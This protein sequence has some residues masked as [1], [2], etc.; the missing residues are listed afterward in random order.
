MQ[1]STGNAIK[2]NTQANV[3]YGFRFS[4]ITRTA[5]S[6]ANTRNTQC[7]TV[8]IFQTSSKATPPSVVMRVQFS[9]DNNDS[10]AALTSSSRWNLKLTAGRAH[11][12]VEQLPSDRL[13]T[14]R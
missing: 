12:R 10:R 14:C 5:A 7:I 2:A 6:T 4:L 3:R 8:P 1:P 13:S 11:S 9:C